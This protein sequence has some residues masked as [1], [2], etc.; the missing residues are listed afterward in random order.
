M[1]TKIECASSESELDSIVLSMPSEMRT[2]LS[3]TID[4]KRRRLREKKQQLQNPEPSASLQ[5]NEVDEVDDLATASPEET[6]SKPKKM[7]M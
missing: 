6:P 2:Q 5:T 1:K 3:I 4:N 7:G